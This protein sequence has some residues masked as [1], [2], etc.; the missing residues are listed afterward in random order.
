MCLSLSVEVAVYQD[1]HCLLLMFDLT[2][3]A[4]FDHLD[5]ALSK[6]L[7]VQS[8]RPRSRSKTGSKQ[9]GTYTHTYM[10]MYVHPRSIFAMPDLT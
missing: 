7:S 6:F 5:A 9:L 8:Q 10:Y 2:S 3:A 1:V 4:S